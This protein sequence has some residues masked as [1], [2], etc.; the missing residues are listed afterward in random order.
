M[1]FAVPRGLTS[2]ESRTALFYFIAFA[3]PGALSAYFGIWLTDR[4]LSAGEIG[5]INSAPIFLTLLFNLYVGRVA[6]RAGDWRTVIIVGAA[7]SLALTVGLFFAGGFWSML[8]VFTLMIL[9]FSLVM[10]VMDAAAMRLTRRNGTNFAFVRAFGTVGYV[11]FLGA[12]ALVVALFGADAYVP[13]LFAITLV[14]AFVALLLPRFRAGR[15]SPVPAAE[16]AAPGGAAVTPSPVLPTQ[17][18]ADVLKPWF[19]APIIAFALVQGLHFILGAFSGLIWRGNGIDEVLVGPLLAL[20][21]VAEIFA[22]L[23]FKRFAGRFT[24]RH[25]I[26]FAMLV[27][28]VRWGG[29]ALNPPL[30]VLALLQITHAVTF[31]VS[32]LGLMN[33]ITNWTSE[34]IAAEA[35]SFAMM[36]QTGVIV[37]SLS[38]FGYLVDLFGNLAFAAGTVTSLI[39][40]GF[41]FWSLR[42][43]PSA[44]SAP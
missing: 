29:M 26:L 28:A 3:M 17:K 6:D 1:F 16:N 12:A 30:V 8:V 43:Q 10:P 35:Q 13:L 32:Y 11:F 4:G 39:G 7:V 25:L 38:S 2:P 37:V 22:M 44:E 20:G 42:L 36:V 31:G 18:L 5:W 24:A 21:S 27:S 9:P 15:G 14:R 23:L 34:D 19:V 41:V 40:A 33:F